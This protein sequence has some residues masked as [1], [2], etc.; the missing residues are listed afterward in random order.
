MWEWIPGFQATASEKHLG[1]KIPAA[2]VSYEFLALLWSVSTPL[3][4]LWY[5]A[6][7]W[8]FP[9]IDFIVWCKWCTHIVM[10]MV[11]GSGV[12]PQCKWCIWCKWC[13]C[14][15]MMVV[16]RKVCTPSVNSVNGVRMM[17]LVL[18]SGV[19]PLCKWCI[20]C[21]WCTHMLLV[22]VDARVYYSVNGVRMWWGWWIM[23]WT[24]C[25]WCKLWKW[26][27]HVVV[28]ANRVYTSV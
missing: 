5:D 13:T 18:G 3:N 22:V 2:V 9:P 4:F 12:L 6:P 19:L 23:G 7:N 11:L 20:W 8:W 15:V 24:Q 17:M 21:K 25:K 28:V 16:V 27:T 10:I 14:V 1:V 26:C